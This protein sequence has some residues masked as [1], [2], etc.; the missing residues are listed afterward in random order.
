MNQSPSKE[1]NKTKKVN[2]KEKSKKLDQ[3]IKPKEEKKIV[4]KTEINQDLTKTYMHIDE[5]EDL[6][7]LRNERSA[8][9]IDLNFLGIYY[10]KGF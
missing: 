6:G 5:L 1:Q 8:H 9:E 10:F 2:K 3:K 4:K 7:P